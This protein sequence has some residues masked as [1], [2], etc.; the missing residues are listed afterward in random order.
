MMVERRF[1]SNLESMQ[2]FDA[3]HYDCPKRT[4]EALLRQRCVQLLGRSIDLNAILAQSCNQSLRKSIDV[5]IVRFEASDLNQIKELESLL[6]VTQMTHTLLS[7]H[8]ALDTWQDMLIEV[9]ERTG[10][11][12]YTGRIYSHLLSEL[13]MDLCPNWCWNAAVARSA[14]KFFFF[15]FLQQIQNLK[16]RKKKI[17]EGA[18]QYGRSASAICI[19]E[20]ARNAP[21]WIETALYALQFPAAAL[22]RFHRPGACGLYLAT[23]R[24]GNALAMHR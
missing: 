24:P 2:G 23:D 14:P 16:R 9:D 15:F 12:Q 18:D 10:F 22:Q 1:K 11:H 7:K 20:R 8:L 6:E 19:C 4:Y 21:F 13:T 17:F 3:G 5:A